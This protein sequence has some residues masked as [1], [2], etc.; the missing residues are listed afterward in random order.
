MLS[1]L[2]PT[3]NFVC[4][5]LVQAV[6]TQAEALRREEGGRFDFEVIVAD[7]ASD[8]STTVAAN[9]LLN[10]L[11]GT[12]L[13]E[14]QTNRGRALLCNWLIDHARFRHVV[15]M[16]ADAAVCTP[17]FVRRY[18]QARH[19]AAVVC[20]SL[21]NPEGPAPKGCELRFRYEQQAMRHRQALL[22]GTADPCLHLSTF[23]LL[24][25]KEALGDLRFD[26]RCRAYGYED[27]LLGLELKRRG[28][29][30]KHI[31]NP[32][33][34]T[35]IDRNEDFLHKTETALLT[36]TGLDG[37]MQREA[38]PSRTLRLLQ[39]WHLHRVAYGLFQL[40]RPMLRHNLLGNRPNLLVFKLYKLGYYATLC[41]K[42]KAH[43][44]L[45]ADNRTA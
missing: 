7:D 35:G 13:V 6:V 25:D 4:T 3:H 18:W 29:T 26:L 38:G 19:D 8:D 32:L 41:H 20:G 9:R 39:R 34:H 24:L 14:H 33:I 30:V 1:F 15:L 40:T 23:N 21:R 10:Q 42:G 45:T 16:D 22:R 36:L 44:E 27:A 43:A 17:D 37:L 31:D 28:L 11:P 12:R 2:I 5:A